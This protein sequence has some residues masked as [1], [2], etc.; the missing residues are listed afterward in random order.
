ML[1]RE[2]S[3]LVNER[4]EAGVHE[5]KFDGSDLQ[6]GCTSTDCRLEISFRQSG[7]YCS[8]RTCLID[9]GG[10]GS[11][12]WAALFLRVG[13]SRTLD[14]SLSALQTL[15]GHSSATVTEI[16]SHLQPDHVGG[17]YSIRHAACL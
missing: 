3:V 8:G 4:R 15:L 16:Y 11:D 6:A 7:Y 13:V 1:G 12:V 10:P 17:T 5:V 2:V 9:S 14:I